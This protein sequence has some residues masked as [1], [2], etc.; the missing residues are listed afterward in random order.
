MNEQNPYAAPAANVTAAPVEV[1]EAVRKQIK[2]A[3]VAGCVS[4]TLTLIVT[5]IAM[6]GASLPGFDAWVL[7]DV[8]L[9]FGLT[10]GIY[11]KS[12]ACAVIMLVYFVVSKLLAM[13][14]A[15]AASGLLVAAIFTYYF[16]QGV[17]G[18]F[19]WYKLQHQA[20]VAVSDHA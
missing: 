19:A 8:A 1:P 20:T 13:M 2:A 10:Y 4:G 16:W 15:G 9:I 7:I 17:A 3:W 5:L 18:T 12:R 14:E 6:G 11:R